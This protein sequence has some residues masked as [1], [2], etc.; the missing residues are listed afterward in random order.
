MAKS[1]IVV[2]FLYPKL[3][4]VVVEFVRNNVETLGTV[5]LKAPLSPRFLYSPPL[6]KRANMRN[7]KCDAD[8]KGEEIKNIIGEP[9]F[10]LEVA[11]LTNL[12]DIG[13][14]VARLAGVVDSHTM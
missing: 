8:V 10:F 1:H 2:P 9:V 14:G 13:E 7:K 4:F 3:I 5:L 11:P 6:V 12:A